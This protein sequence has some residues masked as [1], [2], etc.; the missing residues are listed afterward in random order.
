[1][2]DIMLD[3][4]E[5]EDFEGHINS[6]L[7]VQIGDVSQ[8]ADIVSVKRLSRHDDHRQPFSVIIRSGPVDRHWPQGT[9]ILNHPEHGE[10]M[11]FMVPI[12]PDSEGMR[13]E[14][15]FG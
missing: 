9:Y 2:G 12:G 11:L 8:Q 14:I 7:T 5:P 3:T 4:L 1:M 10:L 13:Y 15:S 6:R